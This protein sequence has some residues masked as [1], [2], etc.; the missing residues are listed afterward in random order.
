MVKNKIDE[1]VSS[2]ADGIKGQISAPLQVVSSV[3]ELFSPKKAPEGVETPEPIER[4]EEGVT[5]LMGQ[6]ATI[7]N[8][9]QS[10][11][12]LD[13]VNINI[14]TPLYRQLGFERRE[15]AM[16]SEENKSWL[17]TILDATQLAL[18]IV[19]CIPGVGEVADLV[20]AGIS[21][22][23]GDYY[24][25]AASLM[26]CIPGVGDA[27]KVAMKGAKM[28]SKAGKALKAIKTAVKVTQAFLTGAGTV[29]TLLTSAN[30]LKDVF[31]LIKE[32][33]FDITNREHVDMLI[34]IGQSTTIAANHAAKKKKKKDADA[35]NKAADHDADGTPKKRQDDPDGS[36]K[37][38][39]DDR[40][41]CASGGDPINLV[42]GS[43]LV[44]EIDIY[45]EDIVKPFYIQRTY[46][47]I[48]SND[49]YMLGSKW[50]INIE[51]KIT[52]D[53]DEA[54][55]LMPDT[56]IE[57]FD[58]KDG[59][60]VNQRAG[61]ASFTLVEMSQGYRVKDLRERLTY[62]YNMA[63]QIEVIID[64]NNNQTLFTYK[65]NILERID[66]ASGQYLLLEYADGKLSTIT[67]TLGRKIKYAYDKDFLTAVTYANGGVM[68]YTYTDKGYIETIT[69]R[70]GI[71]YLK[72]QYDH[73]GRVTRQEIPGFE[74]Y[75]LL[76]DEANRTNTFITTSK[77]QTL[78]L[79]YNKD[80]LVTKTIYEDG[81]Y[82]EVKY[83]DWQ[84]H[85]YERDRNGY[86]IYRKY[87]EKCQ[88]LEETK[89]NGLVTYYE[90]NEVNDLVRRYDNAG[91]ET[92]FIHDGHHNLIQKSS[93]LDESTFV[94][95]N[96]KYDA[97]G[98]R[99]EVSN[100]NG[101]RVKYKYAKPFNQPT[102]YINAEEDVFE[103]AYDEAGRN[104]A[105]TSAYGTVS[106]AYNH[107]DRRTLIID[108]Q[109]HTTKYEYDKMGNIIKETLPNDYNPI[110]AD[111]PSIRYSYN[112]LGKQVTTVDQ[113]GNVFALTRNTEGKVTK[114]IHPNTYDVSTKDGEGIVYVYDQ[115]DRR[116]KTI[117]PD[118]G[119]ERI[120]YNAFGNLTTCEEQVHNRFKYTGQQY[121]PITQQ[122]YLRARYY[123]PV[124]ARFTQEDTYRG[125]G[126]NLY[127]YCGNNPVTYYDPS[128]FK[129]KAICS[130]KYDELK[131][132]K[133]AHEK[134]PTQPGLN[135]HEQKQ[136]DRHEEDYVN[137]NDKKKEKY[138]KDNRKKLKNNKKNSNSITRI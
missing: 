133:E 35:K 109:G 104:M 47:S 70:N 76:Y 20:N 130:D 122:Y 135:K 44:D 51:S 120:K 72:N 18:D 10:Y 12:A 7:F 107:H 131:A 28:A 74:E 84:N 34:T 54:V 46:E 33:K 64:T 19:G 26:G 123:N 101:E 128:G 61:D 13:P 102:T 57:K 30:A 116:I 41:E 65:G 27:A 103:Y 108:E 137:G 56:H 59:C 96:F 118:G 132:K 24:G 8:V 88:L 3:E 21:L 99:T 6:E 115:D 45:L 4:F 81:T 85:I 55:V 111:G 92:K 66:L 125:D 14:K 67:D 38:N 119:I 71:T 15:Y 22:A 2:F 78:Q 90:Y 97:R 91:G 77:N 138:K 73:L 58:Y 9:G 53:G 124:I 50:L 134:D 60:W 62:D 63:G 42:T 112:A 49:G 114:E 16:E 105:F 68:S 95:E 87:N 36:K 23:R 93:R 1:V 100:P 43:F 31:G 98:R 75:I 29:N 25:A 32:G 37:T 110:T 117:Y 69:D 106:F 5:Y 48:Y 82:T 17:D 89:A 127:A 79:V 113:L 86:E 11:L 121:D 94:V 129:A 136:Y 40:L 39:T 80:K 126:L 83:D 52:I